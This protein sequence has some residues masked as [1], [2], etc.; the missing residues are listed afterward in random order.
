MWGSEINS[1]NVT[2]QQSAANQIDSTQERNARRK[3]IDQRAINI[4]NWL[5][6]KP[7]CVSL[8]LTID[9]VSFL[10]LNV[11]YLLTLLLTFTIMKNEAN[12]HYSVNL[13]QPHYRKDNT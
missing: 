9:I 3:T 4:L 7:Y 10:S 12:Q 13:A 8:T 1:E 11:V 2:R 6:R 5:S